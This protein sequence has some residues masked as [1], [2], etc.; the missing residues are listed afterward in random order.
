MYSLFYLCLVLGLSQGQ[1]IVAISEQLQANNSFT[2][3]EGGRD[4]GGLCATG[5][6]QSPIDIIIDDTEEVSSPGFTAMQLDIPPQNMLEIPVEPPTWAGNGT[7][8]GV[9]DS[10][11]NVENLMQIHFHTPSE[12]LING[13]RYPLEMHLSFAPQDQNSTVYGLKFCVLFQEGANS[14]FFASFLDPNGIIDL[15]QLLP[16]SVEDYYYYSGGREVPV[17]DCDEPF[18]YVLP[19]QIFE[20]APEQITTLQQ[21]IYAQVMADSGI[22]GPYKDVVPLNGR[23]VYHRVT[24]VQATSFLA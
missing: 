10:T 19:T 7:I 9:L 13:V 24:Q 4:W 5:R 3:A 2:F 22:H 1:D 16:E 21:G 6:S 12:H 14:E 23:T 20:V 17:S 8:Q 18:L 15:S 11:M